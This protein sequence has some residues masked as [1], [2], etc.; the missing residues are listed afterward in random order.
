MKQPCVKIPCR[1]LKVHFVRHLV[2]TN[3]SEISLDHLNSTNINKVVI[4]ESE[5]KEHCRP[6]ELSKTVASN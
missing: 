6:P 4:P 1:W 5:K 2:T 3:L